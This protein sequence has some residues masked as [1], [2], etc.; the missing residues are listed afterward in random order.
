MERGIIKDCTSK[1][2]I[3][4]DFMKIGTTIIADVYYKELN[5]MMRKLRTMHPKI[6]NRCNPLLLH[7]NAKPH[8]KVY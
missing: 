5:S 2:V 4:Y 1:G 3:H 7:D 8:K 6:V